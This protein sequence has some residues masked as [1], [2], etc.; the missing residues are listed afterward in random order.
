MKKYAEDLLVTL[1]NDE[2][3]ICDGNVKKIIKEIPDVKNGTIDPREEKFF[4]F[5]FV[6]PNLPNHVPL[7]EIAKVIRKGM[8][9]PNLNV[10]ETA[11]HTKYEEIQVEERK[12]AIWRYYQRQEEDNKLKPAIIFVHGGGWMGG[13]PY[14]VENFCRYLA[15]VTAGVVF[16]IDYSLAPEHPFPCGL[17]DVV[18]SIKHIFNN[19]QDYNID[20]ENISIA[21]DSAGANL[22]FGAAHLL[23]DDEKV[24]IKN[25]FLLYI[26]GSICSDAPSPCGYNPNLIHYNIPVGEERLYKC[27]ALGKAKD[28]DKNLFARMYIGREEAT[29]PL[30]YPLYLKDFSRL[31][32]A[33][34]ICPEYDGLRSQ[35]EF[36]IRKISEVQS[37]VLYIMYKGMTHAFIDRIGYVPQAEDCAKMI[38]KV[39][40]ELL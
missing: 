34:F 23:K 26:G 33:I 22:C 12:V 2:Q 7:T 28:Y 27:I 3:I 15:E 24:K 35:A 21:G 17:Y 1:E 4:N 5:D 39:V 37:D 11:I 38:A 31:P 30:V 14:I 18:G 36:L 8:G 6:E 19:W 13:T 40:K 16:N 25:M 9:S 32:R 29:N 10:N 20:Y